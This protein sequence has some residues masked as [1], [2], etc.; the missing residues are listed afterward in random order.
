MPGQLWKPIEGLRDNW[1]EL[2]SSEL[3]VLATEWTNLATK[4]EDSTAIDEFIDRLNREW[5]IETGVIEDV[6]RIDPGTTE[7]LI[8]HG[9]KAS[10]IPHD[11]ANLPAERL[12]EIISAHQ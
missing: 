5:A 11:A 4:L 2:A 7:T 3:E 12:V 6:Y 10:L 1:P 9:I 8:R